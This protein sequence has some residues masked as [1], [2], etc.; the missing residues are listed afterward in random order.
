MKVA[1]YFLL[2]LPL[3][4]AVQKPK[5]DQPTKLVKG[6]GNV[7]TETGRA[8]RLAGDAIKKT[9]KKVVDDSPELSEVRRM[10]NNTLSSAK[11][12]IVDDAKQ[13]GWGFRNAGEQAKKS[14]HWVEERIS[15]AARIINEKWLKPAKE[16]I[17]NAWAVLM[18]KVAKSKADKKVE[19]QLRVAAPATLPRVDTNS[20]ST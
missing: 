18:Q 9:V 8:L 20:T 13:I 12:A 6:E 15:P 11:V 10:A 14:Y 17:A 1:L 7:L 4:E 19:K 16:E 2:A 5:E 3:S